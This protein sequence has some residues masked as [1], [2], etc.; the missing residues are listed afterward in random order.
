MIDLTCAVCKK[1]VEDCAHWTGDMFRWSKKN[2]RLRT[3][4]FRFIVLCD[5]CFQKRI[6]NTEDF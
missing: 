3:D 5:D 6:N 1:N 2:K 4:G